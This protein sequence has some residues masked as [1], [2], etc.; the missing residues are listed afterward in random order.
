MRIGGAQPGKTGLRIQRTFV[1]VTICDTNR[2]QL[3][4]SRH[5]LIRKEGSYAISAEND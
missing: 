4:D 1:N 2:G 5:Q 3:H